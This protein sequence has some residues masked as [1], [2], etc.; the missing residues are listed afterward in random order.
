MRIRRP[1]ATEVAEATTIETSPCAQAEERVVVASAME[2]PLPDHAAREPRLNAGRADQNV[3]PRRVLIRADL[4]LL[5]HA[6]REAECITADR[7]PFPAG[8][9]FLQ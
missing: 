9:R 7:R 3:E 2:S 4:V 1:A 6:D 5:D 8:P